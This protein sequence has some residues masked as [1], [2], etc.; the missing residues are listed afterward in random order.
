MWRWICVCVEGNVLWHPCELKVKMWGIVSNIVLFVF[1]VTPGLALE[2]PN[3]PSEVKCRM[4]Q[5][6]KTNDRFILDPEHGCHNSKALFH[7]RGFDMLQFCTYSKMVYLCIVYITKMHLCSFNNV[8]TRDSHV[9]C[10]KQHI[11]EKRFDSIN[12][13]FATMG[14]IIKYC[15]WI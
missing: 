1:H 3:G 10:Y 2:T 12:N 6:L 5:P 8:M 14:V 11:I 7:E 4:N 13:C 9:Y 15:V